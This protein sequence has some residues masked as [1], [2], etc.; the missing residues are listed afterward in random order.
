MCLAYE[1]NSDLT[2][3]GAFLFDFF[4]NL[5]AENQRLLIVDAVSIDQNAN[6]AAGV[7]DERLGNTSKAVT[8][9]R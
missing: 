1:N 3:I 5:A 2:R 4:S 7:E 6:L 8:N 9:G